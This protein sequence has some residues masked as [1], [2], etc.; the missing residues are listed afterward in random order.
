MNSVQEKRALFIKVVINFLD[1]RM[2]L[3]IA[4]ADGLREE[5]KGNFDLC[6]GADSST[7]K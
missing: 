7:L 6:L 2:S 4:K 5:E 3:L 1:K